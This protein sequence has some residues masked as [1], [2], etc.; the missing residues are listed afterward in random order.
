MKSR[1]NI[2][3]IAVLLVFASSCTKFTPLERVSDSNNIVKAKDEGNEKSLKSAGGNDINDTNSG[4]TITD[5]DHDE[6][7]DADVNITDT[8]NDE[9]YDKDGK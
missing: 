5:P 3:F 9:D 6:D 1:I 4:P 8:D 7:F 2:L